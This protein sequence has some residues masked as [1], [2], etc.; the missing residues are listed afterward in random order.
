MISCLFTIFLVEFCGGSVVLLAEDRTSLMFV[1]FCLNGGYTPLYYNGI[2]LTRIDY[3]EISLNCGKDTGL[4]LRRLGF[5]SISS[6]PNLA[7]Q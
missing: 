7:F 1:R 6:H 5:V 3:S 2:K 4:R